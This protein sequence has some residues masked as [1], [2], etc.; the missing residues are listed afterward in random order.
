MA[1]YFA[2]I[3]GN[4]IVT[5]IQVVTDVSVTNE[6]QGKNFL[7]NL[8]KTNDNWVETFIDGSQ[9]ANY[10]FIGGT[11][12]SVNNVFISAKPYPSWILN[13]ET[14]NWDP[15]IPEPEER[16]DREY[17]WNE[18]AGL[19]FFRRTEPPFTDDDTLNNP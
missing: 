17:Y 5:E 4:N 3:D 12:D 19:W 8:F 16:L 1:K 14:W 2:K 6:E 7:N 11:Y 15:P 9:R 13:T 10:A 18:Q